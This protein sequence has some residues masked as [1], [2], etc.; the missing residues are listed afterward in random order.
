MPIHAKVTIDRGSM[1]IDLSGCSAERKA[2]IN[3]RTYAGARVAYKALTGPLEPVNEG[4]F[5]ALKVIIPEGNIMMARYPAPMSGWS[6]IVPTVVDTIVKALGPA[7]TDR[8]PA[9]HHGLLGGSIVFFGVHPKTQAPL[10]GAEHRGRRLG[11]TAHRGR[12]VRHRLGLP[13]RR[14]QRLDRGHRAEMPGRGREP[15]A[16]HGFRRRRQASRRARPRYLRAQSGRR[17]LEFR[18]SASREQCP[19][20]GL[21][22]GKAGTHGDFLLRQPGENDFRSMDATHYPVPV[23]SEV[24]VRTGGGGGW[25]DPV[26]RDPALVRADVIEELVS[27]RAAEELYGVVLRDDLTL[28]EAETERRRNALRSAAKREEDDGSRRRDI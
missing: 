19:P 8:V 24:I 15:G 10:R 1:T 7:M 25:G 28:D 26:E 2:A 16:A 5:R 9:G 11:R 6:M 21:W 27:R 17:P 18:S 23:Q 22:G 4:S 12:R 20:W 13:G 3:S 14:A